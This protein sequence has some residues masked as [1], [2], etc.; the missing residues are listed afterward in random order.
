MRRSLLPQFGPQA[1]APCLG[2]AFGRGLPPRDG[3]LE[4]LKVRT[5]PR[6][7]EGSSGPPD[8]A[9]MWHFFATRSLAAAL[10][11]GFEGESEV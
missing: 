3:F 2:K 9:A 4:R 8:P 10:Q 1:R 5:A 7:L 11:E 6:V